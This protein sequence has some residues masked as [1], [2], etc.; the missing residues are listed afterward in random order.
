[1]VATRFDFGGPFF[2]RDPKLTIRSNIRSMMDALAA[3]AEK[4]VQGQIAGKAGSMPHYTG[5]TRNHVV[6]RTS[7]LGGKRWAVSAV[8]SANTSGMGARDAI[9]TLAAAASIERRWR[10]F[11]RTA[12][13]MR[14]SR[15][16]I[17]ANL[18]RGI[19]Q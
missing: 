14:R 11:A 1:M 13:A 19:E 8:V 6:G 16:A 9:R 18:T 17:N 7:S 2:T 5:W 10:P 4:D 12:S 3:E 15:A